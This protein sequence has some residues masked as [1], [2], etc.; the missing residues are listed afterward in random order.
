MGIWQRGAGSVV[1][2]ASTYSTADRW[3]GALGTT[4]L[5]LTL[6]ST[7][8]SGQ[9]FLY[10]LQVATTTATGSTPLIEQRIEAVN[11]QDLLSG[12][13]VT[14]TFWASQTSGTLMPLQVGLYVPTTT[15]DTFSAQ[16]QTG[17][18]VTTATLSG[19][20]TQY[21]ATFTLTTA[22]TLST[23][24]TGGLAL[25]FTS[26]AT[27]S[28]CTF[29][30]TGVQLEIGT[31]AT[32][33]EYRPYTIDLILCLRYYFRTADTGNNTYLMVGGVESSTAGAVTMI[34]PVSMRI[35]PTATLGSGVRFYSVNT[36]TIIATILQQRST[37][38]NG[39]LAL[40][41]SGGSDG[42]V[43]GLYNAA[44]ESSY[45]EFNSEL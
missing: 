36:G 27:A 28:A 6:S 30:I 24:S 20:L 2:A 1:T 4:N 25:R 18:T 8:P 13:S 5:T 41:I 12:T 11:V 45:I 10:S 39:G 42:Q 38:T 9:G 23:T 32:S 31:V 19:T 33:F 34:F 43:C 35:S 17:T 15:T 7:V 29:L 14:V 21:T 3:C 44:V 37:N 16:T 40:T 22:G 26:G